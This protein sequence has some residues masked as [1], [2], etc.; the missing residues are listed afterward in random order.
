MKDFGNLVVTGVGAVAQITTNVV[1]TL[2][3]TLLFTLE[4]PGIVDSFWKTLE[5]KRKSEAIGAFKHLSQRIANVISTYVSRQ[6]LVAVLDGC[7]V[8]IA[9][10][11]L[12]L[13]CGFSGRLALPMGLVAFTFYL[14]PMFGP[15]ISC[16]LISLLLL[17][18][19]PVAAVIFLIFYIVY[20]Q[21]ENNFIAPKIQGDALSL[22]TALVLTA[23]VIGMYMFGLIGAIIAIPIAGCIKVVI[24]ELPRLRE[25]EAQS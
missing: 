15:I 1:L 17:F 12:S 14:I 13:T 8:T 9:I 5:G 4:G 2:I 6:V 10:L 18:S 19:S 23:I 24:E 11:L 16:V 22:P 25:A 21:I 7:M 20:E 3:L